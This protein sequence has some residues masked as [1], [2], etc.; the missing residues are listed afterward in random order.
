MT[1]LNLST[2]VACGQHRSNS[3]SMLDTSCTWTWCHFEGT[4]YNPWI[5]YKSVK[6]SIYIKE[7]ENRFIIYVDVEARRESNCQTFVTWWSWNYWCEDLQSSLDDIRRLF[8]DVRGKLSCQWYKHHS[9]LLLQDVCLQKAKMLKNELQFKRSAEFTIFNVC[10]V[11]W[12]EIITKDDISVVVQR[13]TEG[14]RTNIWFV[15]EQH[16][17]PVNMKWFR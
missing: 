8:F 9:L 4:F 15:L 10:N 5:Q 1:H 14:K 11:D 12:E 2:P 16:A 7:E 17:L 13:G 6:V 3:G